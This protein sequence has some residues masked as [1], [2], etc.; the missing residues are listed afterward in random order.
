MPSYLSL[1]DAIDQF[2]QKYGLREEVE[3]Q[4]FLTQWETHVGKPIAA[5]T[6]KVWFENGVLYIRMNGPVWKN[7]LLLA[8]QKLK[9]MINDKAGRELV[10][11]VKVV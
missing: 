9:H 3:I 7:E 8:R 1:G 5:N 4:R 11:E 2:L 10:R 6:E